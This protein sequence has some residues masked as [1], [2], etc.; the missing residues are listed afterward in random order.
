MG[1][2]D[3]SRSQ[4][5]LKRTL[6]RI[7]HTFYV[8]IAVADQSPTIVLSYHQSPIWRKSDLR[9]EKDQSRSTKDRVAGFFCCLPKEALDPVYI[10]IPTQIQI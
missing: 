8:F 10:D 1:Y 7:L 3:Q 4:N 2:V 6:K 9:Q 5:P